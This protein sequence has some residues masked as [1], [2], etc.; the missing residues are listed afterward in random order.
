MAFAAL[1]LLQTEIGWTKEAGNLSG[2]LFSLLGA[3]AS[4]LGMGVGYLFLYLLLRCHL[5]LDGQKWK[6]FHL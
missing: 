1:K 6:M 3:I 5:G 2:G 4:T